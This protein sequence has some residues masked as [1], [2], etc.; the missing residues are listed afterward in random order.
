MLNIRNAPLLVVMLLV[1]ASLY[2][3]NVRYTNSDPMGSLLVSE[4]I[5][6]NGSIKLDSFE[7][8]A[9]K[10][11]T[12]RIT[13]K[14]GHSYYYFPIGTSL[15][16][17]PF[18]AL[19]NAVGL[20][21]LSDESITQ[22]AIVA[23]CSVLII[24]FLY[25]I[26]RRFFSNS[27]SIFLA[28][29]FWFGTSLSSAAGTA[30]WSH[31][32]AV[33]FALSGIYGALLII[34]KAPLAWLLTGASIFLAYLCRPTMAL[35]GVIAMIFIAI[36][37]FKA[38]LRTLMLLL[39]LLF[40]FVAVS[41]YEFGQVLPDYYLPQRLSGGHFSEAIYGNLLSP[42]RGLLVFSP[43]F[44]LLALGFWSKS[45][46]KIQIPKSLLAFGV[47]WP[48][49]HLVVISRFPHWWAGH[50][51]GPRLMT[52]VIPGLYV[53]FLF[54]WVVIRS[55]PFWTKLLFTSLA[56]ASIYIN[57]I[58]GLYNPLTQVWNGYPNVDEHPEVLFDWR[59]PQFLY[60]AAMHEDRLLQYSLKT[61][62]R[63]H[64][65][66]AIN[67]VSQDVVYLGWSSPEELHRWSSG[68]ESKIVLKL[69]CS[70]ALMGK[71]SLK[72]GTLGRQQI[73]IYINDNLVYQGT[74][75]SWSD[76]LLV[77]FAPAIIDTAIPVI[78]KFKLPDA[79]V[80]GNGDPRTLAF[81]IR[82]FSLE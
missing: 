37:D 40:S 53:C 25:L 18:V 15:V 58:Q 12:Y 8:S 39:A 54:S 63:L 26:S 33:L 2:F 27:E 21:M 70:S 60:G 74:R 9:L 65:G 29:L 22:M 30:L 77:E 78:I 3:A 79:V 80:A 16:A 75:E 5:L 31:D 51:F 61:L 72:F 20:D 69:S 42:A 45:S 17:I 13:Q 46:A 56:I 35:F 73:G 44:L 6:S 23:V 67:H 19:A 81:A 59:H 82:E 76:Q 43:F 11:Y 55:S 7:A 10:K 66:Q 62:P 49:L 36:N 57:T 1:V 32:F 50:S 4:S 47:V 28:A 71:L 48:L 38:A 41:Y 34:E 24:L 52:D 68:H 64:A 14:N